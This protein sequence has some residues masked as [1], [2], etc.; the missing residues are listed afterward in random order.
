M[1]APRVL[2]G[3]PPK[4]REVAARRLD[5]ADAPADSGEVQMPPEI[6]IGVDIDR[7]TRQAIT[8]LARDPD[9]YQRA[10]ALVH[11]AHVT[12][13]EES[14]RARLPLGAPVIVSMT[15]AT[16]RSRLSRC[17]EWTKRTVRDG[18][19]RWVATRPDGDAV[20]AALD[21][22]VWPDVP[23]LVGVTECP[24]LRRDGS[25]V[26]VPG[27]DVATGYLYLPGETYPR[28]PDVPTQDDARDALKQLVEPFS[29]F[30]FE[31]DDARFVPVAA[32]LTILARAAIGGSVPAFAHDASTRGSGKTLAA[33]VVS[34]I[35]TGRTTRTTYPSDAEEF[36]K[37]LDGYALSG[38]SVIV[39]DN[40][41][42]ALG[43][44]A[45]D[46]YLT[47]DGTVDVRILGQTG[48][49]R[50]PWCGVIIPTGNNL[51]PRGDT[52]RRLLVGRLEPR[53][54][55]PEDRANFAHADLRAYVRQSRPRLVAAAL[56]IL[57][58]FVTAGRPD[59]GT[60]TWG[61]FES[62]AALIPPAIVY[63]G[64][65]NVLRC[66]LAGDG[67]TDPDVR[68]L[69]VLVT[70][71]GV[72]DRAHGGHGL[73]ARDVVDSLYSSER[74]RGESAPDGYDDLRDA[75][76]QL[77]RVPTGRTPSAR[78]IGDAF[79]RN[80]G[81]FV[82][83]RRL[84]STTDTHEKV[85]RWAVDELPPVAGSAGSCGVS[86]RVNKQNS[87]SIHMGVK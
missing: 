80:R 75:V 81:R 74:R 44:A 9:T 83:R 63:A 12:T 84:I 46:A 56:T 38:A 87:Q 68:A 61:S 60:G 15:R 57:R 50:I 31:P 55:R 33:D 54:E 16:L 17:A 79:R 43:G 24:I 23:S 73:R 29:E 30:P 32:V 41:V 76:E 13:D 71:L 4:V 51:D 72:L 77:A 65:P 64:G 5:A 25:I 2:R 59:Q 22:R 26:Q 18:E 28:I 70:Q 21:A 85:V 35:T 27:Y 40:V 37:V 20:A 36:R 49:H 53:C 69:E 8:A 1:T 39:V 62:W 3:L 14:R 58:A 10:G 66:R 7:M 48:Q 78:Q 52:I 45:L 47:S 67:E 19:T 6:R 82:G 34:E 42:G 11:V 86:S